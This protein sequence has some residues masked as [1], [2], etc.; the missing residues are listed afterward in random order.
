MKYIAVSPQG[1]VLGKCTTLYDS[2][3]AAK[4]ECLRL[5]GRGNFKFKPF[6]AAFKRSR[7]Y[8]LHKM[9]MQTLANLQKY[10]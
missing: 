4:A 6:N 5:H 8:K 9:K 10:R 3:E 1:K 2:P 7:A